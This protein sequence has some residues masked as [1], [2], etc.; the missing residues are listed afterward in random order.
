MSRDPRDENWTTDEDG[1]NWM[2]GSDGQYMIDS[3]GER[4]PGPAR[5]NS[6]EGE[7]TTFDTSQ[8][9]CGLCGSLH[10]NGRCFK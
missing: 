10:C 4:V 8:G 5:K 3:E 9:H 6:K 1:R 7:F 2:V